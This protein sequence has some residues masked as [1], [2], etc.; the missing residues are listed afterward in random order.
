MPGHG[1]ALDRFDGYLSVLP[2][3]IAIDIIQYTP[4]WLRLS[5]L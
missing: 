1:G 5:E 3:I 4:F 2:L